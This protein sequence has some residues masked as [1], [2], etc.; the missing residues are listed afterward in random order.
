MTEN[1]R[2]A[3]TKLNFVIYLLYQ[4]IDILNGTHHLNHHQSLFNGKHIIITRRTTVEKQS[5]IHKFKHYNVERDAFNHLG[6]KN[7]TL[8]NTT[9]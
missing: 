1:M 3:H 9:Q 2:T 7:I 4:C 5:L 8:Q 6:S